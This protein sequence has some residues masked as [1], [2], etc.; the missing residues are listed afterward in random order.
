VSVVEPSW[1]A[2]HT[3]SHCEQRVAFELSIRRFEAY[4]PVFR[5]QHQW[6]DRK[7]LVELPLFPGYVFVRMLDLAATRLEVRKIDK[8]V[9]I[10]GQGDRIER[11]ADEEIDALKRL[12]SASARCHAHPL[13]REGAWVRVRRGALEGLEGLLIG[14]KSQSRLVVS[15]TLLSQSVSTEIDASDVEFLRPSHTSLCHTRERAAT[16]FSNYDENPSRSRN[17]RVLNQV[18][19]ATFF[20]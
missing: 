14:T 20:R 13:L 8:V 15:I 16:N 11:V 12:L 2:L 10:L 18:A 4:L 6:K 17:T 9:R 3:H 5:E 7:K 1:Y 19:P